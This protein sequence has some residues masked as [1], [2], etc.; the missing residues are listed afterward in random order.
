MDKA[1]F[2]IVVAVSAAAFITIFCLVAS[3][4]LFEQYGHNNRVKKEKEIALNQLKK[5]VTNA[6]ELFDSY[7]KFVAANPNVLGAN[8]FG[9]ADKE[10]D[11][12][13]IVLDALPSKYDYPGLL[14]SV[15]KILKDK[16][17][18]IESVSGTDD[19]VAQKA[20]QSSPDPQPLEIP[21]QVAIKG[22][23]Q[24]T[25]E[26]ISTLASS[27][28]PMSIKTINMEGSDSEVKMSISAITYWQPEVKVELKT[29]EVK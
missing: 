15:E 9:T 22:S 14:S 5:N 17:Y 1:N 12:A 16:S 23:Y 2:T 7:K 25:R 21:F 6:G 26:L 8:N 24:S 18:K 28:R 19:E 13:K 27:I 4:S 3:N 29:K 10:G 20:N 11:N